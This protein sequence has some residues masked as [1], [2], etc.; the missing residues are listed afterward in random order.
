MPLHRLDEQ[1]SE[2]GIL[3]DITC[4]SDGT[5]KQFVDLRDVRETI[6]LH[7]IENGSPYYI[8]VFLVGAYQE[9]LGDLH[10]LFGDTHAVH[11]SVGKNGY[12]IDKTVE[13]DS[14]GE[15]L[16]YVQFNRR[17][18]LSRLRQ[19]VESALRAGDMSL[20]DA[21]PFMREIETGLDHYTYYRIEEPRPQKARTGQA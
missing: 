9:I 2:R 12:V 18:I 4:D 8:G 5:I 17:D 6:P 21:A 11:V 15:V 1:P 14:V 13:G 3:A 10:N 19:R 7:R 16:E 20:S